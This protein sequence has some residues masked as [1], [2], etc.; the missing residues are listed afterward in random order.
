MAPE[1]DIAVI[2]EG[3][4][5]TAMLELVR[6][7]GVQ[8]VQGYLPGR[9]S[10]TLPEAS[11]LQAPGPMAQVGRDACRHTLKKNA[12]MPIAPTSDISGG[13]P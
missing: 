6:Q 13:C 9:P 10:E 1:A 5:K 12:R 11:A 3:I 4:E 7:A 8:A 2:A